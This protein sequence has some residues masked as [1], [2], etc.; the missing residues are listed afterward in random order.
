VI[1]SWG[2]GLKFCE[3]F[4]VVAVLKK[5]NCFFVVCFL[6]WFL[7]INENINARA[8]PLFWV[9]VMVLFTVNVMGLG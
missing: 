9:S 5:Y 7:E 2:V 3:C 6:G 8:F 1:V 4:V